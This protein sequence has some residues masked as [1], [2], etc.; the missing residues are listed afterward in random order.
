L[1]L[2]WSSINLA[3]LDGGGST[4]SGGG[5]DTVSF[6]GSSSNM[7]LSGTTLS[8]VISNAQYLDFSGTS[9]TASMSLAGED[10]QKILTGSSSLSS[11]AG[12]LDL[13]FDANGDSLTLLGNPNY[14]FW[15][16][17]DVNATTGRIA[18][19]SRFSIT[20]GETYVYVFNA[21]HTTLLA[22]LHY[23]T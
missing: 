9:G 10:I 20:S 6:A 17:N 1:Q 3:K 21:D 11:N 4:S 13:K 23:H 7:S 15:Q 5:L 18:D 8:S 12:T 16:S 14:S 22:T 2:D 19:G